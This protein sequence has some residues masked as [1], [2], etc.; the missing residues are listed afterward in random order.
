MNKNILPI[1][2]FVL[3]TYSFCKTK[4][5]AILPFENL[6]HNPH[7]K[8][9]NNIIHKKLF[10]QAD[11]SEKYESEK[12]LVGCSISHSGTFLPFTLDIL[13]SFSETSH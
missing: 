5:A 7:L 3:S 10:I 6:L 4:V 12:E 13:Q 9:V 8:F 11:Q 2:M 1:S